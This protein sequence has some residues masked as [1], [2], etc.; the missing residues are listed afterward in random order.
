V[1]VQEGVGADIFIS[2]ARKD[3]DRVEPIARAIES[4]GYSVWWDL[5]LR[6]GI[7]F[8]KQIEQAIAAAGAVVVLW[9][10]AAAESDWVRAEAAEALEARKL[11]PVFLDRVK[12]PLRFRNVHCVDLSG[13]DGR[14][15][16]VGF[17]RLVR[18][19]AELAG[20]SGRLAESS[21]LLEAKSGFD[22]TVAAAHAG[23]G[24]PDLII[25]YAGVDHRSGQ[26]RR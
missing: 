23:L 16:H 26:A 20:L 9:T 11:V 6:S 5:E 7:P 1:I 13:W 14:A 10:Q 25:D 3:L 19:I 24:S 17:Q 15:A 18:D 12:L 2:Y 4:L 21:A 8:D 22:E